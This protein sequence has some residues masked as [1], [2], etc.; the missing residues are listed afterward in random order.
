MLA[1]FLV[2]ACFLLHSIN[3]LT[4]RFCCGVVCLSCVLGVAWLT[5]E[6]SSVWAAEGE[7]AKAEQLLLRLS[8]G[9]A[10]CEIVVRLVMGYLLFSQFQLD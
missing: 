6:M 2:I 10:F 5:V 3:R 8:V 4:I 7:W 9:M 1:D